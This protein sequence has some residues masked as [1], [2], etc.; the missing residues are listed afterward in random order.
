MSPQEF[1]HIA[2]VRKPPQKKAGLDADVFDELAA[3]LPGR[4]VKP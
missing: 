1:W 2:E 3:M 4:E